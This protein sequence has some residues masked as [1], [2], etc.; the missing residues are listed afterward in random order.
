MI[1]LKL[2][3]D[4]EVWCPLWAISIMKPGA[5]GSEDFSLYLSLVGAWSVADVASLISSLLVLLC[6]CGWK[7]RNGGDVF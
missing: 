6:F 2:S 5:E 4:E 3:G 1:G 7:C